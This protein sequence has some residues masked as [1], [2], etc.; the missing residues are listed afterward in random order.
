MSLAN[1]DILKIPAV[2]ET[3]VNEMLMFL[4]HKMD[5]AKLEAELRDKAQGKN[6]TRL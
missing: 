1:D 3:E 5:K 4:A 2:L 6:V